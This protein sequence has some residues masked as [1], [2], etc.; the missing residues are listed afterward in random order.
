[1][2]LFRLITLLIVL[3]TAFACEGKKDQ[4]VQEFN[5]VVEL[6]MRETGIETLSSE[7]IN[8]L[9]VDTLLIVQKRTDP[10]LEIYSTNSHKLIASF[11]KNGQGPGEIMEPVLLKQREFE[12]GDP[13]ITVFDH[14]RRT[15][16]KVNLKNLLLNQ[17]PIIKQEPLPFKGSFV[18]YFYHADQD[19]IFGTTEG[20]ERFTHY[21]FE[22]DS[23]QFI[24]YI[25]DLNIEME[26]N[27]KGRV[28]RSTVTVNKER[29][30]IAAFPL[31]FGSLDFFDLAGKFQTNTIFDDSGKFLQGINDKD[32]R[33]IGHSYVFVTDSDSDQKNIY[34]LNINN[35][36]SVF[37][38]NSL[39]K[40]MQIEVF[41]WDGNPVKQYVLNN[42]MLSESFA[43]DEKHN[44]FYTYCREC[45]SSN[46]IFYDADN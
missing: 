28:Y 43:Y 15:V 10:I 17:E 4:T 21:S 42:E 8:L 23:V 44:R 6:A 46:I 26:D 40:M 41:D 11:G 32:D 9:V 39:P 13:I 18:M 36:S 31:G 38:G 22:N 20:N 14:R 24:P 2:K 7:N 12:N 30:L 45:E 34:G 33:G 3:V 27:L 1:M 37:Q 19:F 16:N 5:S 35:L 25:P 29:G